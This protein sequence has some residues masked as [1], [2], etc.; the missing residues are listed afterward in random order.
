MLN[1]SKLESSSNNPAN[2]AVPN[3]NFDNF[4]FDLVKILNYIF[5]IDLRIKL[6]LKL[7]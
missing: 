1:A 5:Y 4:K 6:K 2:G 3:P 7:D